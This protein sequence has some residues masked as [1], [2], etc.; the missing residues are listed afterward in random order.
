MGSKLRNAS[1]DTA[2]FTVGQMNTGDGEVPSHLLDNTARLFHALEVVREEN[3]AVP[4]RIISGYRSVDGNRKGAK[5]QVELDAIHPGRAFYSEHM[6]GSAADCVP[7]DGD[8]MRLYQSALRVQRCEPSTGIGYVHMYAKNGVPTFVHIDTGPSDKI[9]RID[10][11][12]RCIG[13]A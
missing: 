8:V 7:A 6:T 1:A 3:G 2:N 12:K 10:F 5:S 4:I 13:E 9:A 11:V